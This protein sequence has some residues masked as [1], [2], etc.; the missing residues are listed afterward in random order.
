[1]A[2]YVRK[3]GPVKA[4]GDLRGRRVGVPEW[5]QTAGV[6][7][8][9]LL[10]DEYKVDLSSIKWFQAGQDQAGRKEKASLNLAAGLIVQEVADK[11]LADML[12]EGELDAII[13]AQPP[14]KFLQ[15]HHNIL[16]LFPNAVEIEHEYAERT[17]IVPIMHT[18]AMR[19]TILDQH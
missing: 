16:R 7:A 17:H 13:C 1:S 5:A 10:T 14:V 18:I 11:A 8:R 6:Y 15:G 2:F 9:G 3:D 19:K 12:V 4:P